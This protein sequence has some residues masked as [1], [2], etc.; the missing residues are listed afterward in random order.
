MIRAKHS[1]WAD[2]LFEK[3]L[4]RLLKNHFYS[5]NVLSEYPVIKT[6][7]PLIIIPNHS[8]WW[9]GFLIYHLNKRIF[10]RRMF[11]MM[12]EKQLKKFPFFSKL[13]AFGVN[14]KS[15]KSILKSLKYA[16]SILKN[17]ES[18]LCV[19]PQG[20]LER[21]HKRPVKY[22]RGIEKIVESMEGD[23]VLLP[24]GIRAE[25]TGEQRPEIFL[26]FGK[27][28]LVNKTNFPGIQALESQHERLLDQ[29]EN[30]VKNGDK[31]EKIFT[32]KK[33]LSESK[34]KR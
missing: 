3:Y 21:W 17:A 15:V 30:K 24:L 2:K 11:V 22:K 25:F 4:N 31:G 6:D 32:G 33:S 20:V 23:S 13:G 12:E 27:S 7:L 19:F 18:M 10:G 29:L 16:N 34:L 9:D 8:T 14:A 28:M 5:I 26:N 1:I